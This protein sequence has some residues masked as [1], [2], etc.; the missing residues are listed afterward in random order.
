MGAGT[1][2][3]VMIV[4]KIECLPERAQR[5]LEEAI[6]TKSDGGLQILGSN[7]RYDD[8]YILL[9]ICTEKTAVVCVYFSC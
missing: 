5:E 3:K 9:Q 6:Y 4:E 2:G 8:A 7:P 1:W